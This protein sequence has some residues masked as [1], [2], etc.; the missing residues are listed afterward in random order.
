M[1][2]LEILCHYWIKFYQF[3][4]LW[5]EVYVP[6]TIIT[7]LYFA[8]R[9]FMRVPL[10]WQVLIYFMPECQVAADITSS[11]IQNQRSW[12]I[13]N[14]IFMPKKEIVCEY[15]RRHGRLGEIIVAL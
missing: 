13:F 1:E 8:W 5:G 2:S 11:Y 9:I 12:C 4:G 10:S 15:A 6:I 14:A 3:S 7:R